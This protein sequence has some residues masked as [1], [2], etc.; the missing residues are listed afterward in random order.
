[1][2]VSKWED[3]DGDFPALDSI[4]SED[5]DQDEFYRELY[6]PEFE[7][8]ENEGKDSK[9]Q[10]DQT[11]S[12]E[13]Q[14]QISSEHS[15][16]LT[17]KLP[18]FPLR[19]E[20]RESEGEKTSVRERDPRSRTES[21]A[22][23]GSPRIRQGSRCN[24]SSTEEASSEEYD[25]ETGS[26]DSTEEHEEQGDCGRT[27][28]E[29]ME[30][31]EEWHAEG[32]EG[33][34]GWHAEGM[35]GEEEWHAEGKEEDHRGEE[36]EQ[37]EREQAERSN[38]DTEGGA[39]S[40]S[41]SETAL[42]TE[43]PVTSGSATDGSDVKNQGRSRARGIASIV[44]RRSPSCVPEALARSEKQRKRK[45]SS[46]VDALEK[47]QTRSLK[48]ILRDAR[49]F[50]MRSSSHENISL[51]KARAIWSAAPATER[52]L[53][54]AF[55][56]VRNVILIFSVSGSR[57]FQGFA[58]LSSE[59]RHGGSPIHWVPPE[60]MSPRRLAGVFQIDWLCR[61]ELPF[62]RSFHLTN[63]LNEHKP[64]RIGRDGQE[65][66]LECG[67]QLCLLFPRDERVD[68]FPV[69]EKMHRKR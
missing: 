25:P 28:A 69:M 18:Q 6:D 60:G 8:G 1:M 62:S 10:G 54:A 15:R 36:D 40:H 41:S 46:S 50:L 37:E 26:G 39:A 30:G 13:S 52:Q 57:A 38:S 64:V 17:S 44:L 12:A 43:G 65:V 42:F 3:E 56:S 58:R 20:P 53:N 51:A 14:S 47:E 22:A 55:R 48:Y 68:L 21:S 7:E 67:T 16:Q 61:H 34:E 49:F 33:E 32:M 59:S 23:E 5:H 11:E 35:E 9:G 45:S 66:D 24:L 19:W 29:G 63:A 31:E 27:E 4:L 2:E